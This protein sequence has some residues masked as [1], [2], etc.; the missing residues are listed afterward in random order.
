MQ[1]SLRFVAAAAFLLPSL[2]SGAALPADSLA[3][4]DTTLT[5][6]SPEFNTL[7][8]TRREAE[9]SLE[10]AQVKREAS[11]LALE[12]YEQFTARSIE[13]RGPA[14]EAAAQAAHDAYKA[15]QAAQGGYKKKYNNQK[16]TWPNKLKFATEALGYA[17]AYVIPF[18]FSFLFL[19]FPSLFLFSKGNREAWF[20]MYSS[21]KETD[22]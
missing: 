20:R 15:A 7:G 21:K 4:R 11:A 16:E 9:A 1:F 14:D 3:A 8:L 6:R 22:N 19:P 17:T 10:A 12:D 2:I 13:A 18:P 5:Q